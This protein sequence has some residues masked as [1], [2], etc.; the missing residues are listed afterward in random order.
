MARLKPLLARLLALLLF[1][2][3]G[4][5]VAHCLRGIA[6]GQGLLVEICAVEGKRLMVLGPD[7]API[8]APEPAVEPGFC[9]V[10]IGLP[11]V[12]VP[13]PSVRLLAPAPI[14]EPAWHGEGTAQRLAPARAPPHAPRGPPTLA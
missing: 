6:P 13:A 12:A 4:V 5:A 14:A 9:P 8:E 3:S 2:Q 1:V 10:C 11:E 7:G